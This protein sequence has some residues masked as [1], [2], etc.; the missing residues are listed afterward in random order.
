MPAQTGVTL[1]NSFVSGSI[2]NPATTDEIYKRIITWFFFKGDGQYFSIPW[3]KRR[4]MRF[5][6]GTNGAAPN[7]DN[8]YPVSV[9]FNGSVVTITITLTDAFGIP[10]SVAQLLQLAINAGAVCMPFQ[11]TE[12]VVIINNLGPTG[13]GNNGSLLT[14]LTATGWPTSPSGLSAG[15]VWDDGGIA[16]VVPGQTPNPFASAQFYGLLT[17]GGLLVLGGGD[18][19]LTNP[20]VVDQLWNDGGLIA[21]SNG[22][23]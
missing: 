20:H 6:I 23:Q 1:A 10:L 19:P 15:A 3:L 7:I 21:V 13:L 9:V 8:T 22:K 4:I 11:L 5:L 18:L 17:A 2:Q 16:A 12:V 14:V